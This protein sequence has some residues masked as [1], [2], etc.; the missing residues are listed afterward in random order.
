METCQQSCVVIKIPLCP[1]K[2]RASGEGIK[3][4]MRGQV[5]VLSVEAF[6]SEGVPYTSPVDSLTCELVTSD[7]S[8]QSGAL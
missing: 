5:A 3:V 6:D 1:D 7:G 8:S 2:C 4:A